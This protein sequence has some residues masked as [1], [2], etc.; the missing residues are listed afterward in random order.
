MA[1]RRIGRWTDMKLMVE[2]CDSRLA[3]HERR[4]QALEKRRR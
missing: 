2:G 4:I 3:D 1:E